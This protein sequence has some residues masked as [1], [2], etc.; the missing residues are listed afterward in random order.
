ML[1]PG[2][3]APD[4]TAT[5]TNGRT[6]RLSD[7]RGRRVVLFFFPKAFTPGCTLETRQF[8]DHYAELSG[9]GAEVIGISVD[10]AER[11]CE[12][13]AREGASFP[14]IGDES[15][16]ICRSYGVLWPL[17]HVAQRVTY[18]IDETGR[19]EAVFH[20]ELLIQRHVESVRRHLLSR[21]P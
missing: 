2:D 8:R 9:L 4:F 11:Q 14:L 17:L 20:H 10:S 3:L 21:R 1:K 19:I 6:L 12:F 13:A 16:T 18:V 15:G 7:L 5:T